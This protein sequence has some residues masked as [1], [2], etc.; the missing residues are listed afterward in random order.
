MRFCFRKNF[1]SLFI[2][3][4]LEKKSP[5]S[6]NPGNYSLS[7]YVNPPI[8]SLLQ[9]LAALLLYSTSVEG[10]SEKLEHEENSLVY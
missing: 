4:L 5:I 6:L 8:E 3:F 9:M 7:K 10:S 2:D 1:I